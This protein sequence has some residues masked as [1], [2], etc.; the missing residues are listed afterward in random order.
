MSFRNTTASSLICCSNLDL[1]IRKVKTNTWSFL[2]INYNSLIIKQKETH[3][4]ICTAKG[5]ISCNVIWEWGRQADMSVYEFSVL[6]TKEF[7][8]C[9][10]PTKSDLE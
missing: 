5:S 10:P 4:N 8:T 7:G 9:F 1:R 6:K 2:A 3:G